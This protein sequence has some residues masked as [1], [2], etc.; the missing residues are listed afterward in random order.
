[1]RN[2]TREYIHFLYIALGSLGELDT[3][4]ELSHQLGFYRKVEEDNEQIT[5]LKKQ[6]YALI[7]R[8]K[9]K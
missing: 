2:G 4:I 6:L 5:V 7:K 1:M 8:L 3:Q 9:E